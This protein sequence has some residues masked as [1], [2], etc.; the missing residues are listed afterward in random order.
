MK[1]EKEIRINKISSWLD[2]ILFGFYLFFFIWY[3]GK[4]SITSLVL[5]G[6]Y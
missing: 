6:I 5:N 1:Q 3:I 4:F 2:I